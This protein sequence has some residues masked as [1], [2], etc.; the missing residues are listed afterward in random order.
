MFSDVEAP[1]WRELLVHDACPTCRHLGLGHGCGGARG[2]IAL[3]THRATRAVP[4]GV[5]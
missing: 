2:N 4:R 5:D 3:A 1:A